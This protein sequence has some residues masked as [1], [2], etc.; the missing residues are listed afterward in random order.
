[1]PFKAVIFDLDG[2]LADT[3]EDIADAM[4]RTLSVNGYPTH[5]YDIYR[6]LVGKGL[7][8]LVTRSLPEQARSETVIEQCYAEML[9]DYTENYINKTRPYSGIQDLLNILSQRAVKMAVLSNKDDTIT[10]KI[11]CKLFPD[12]YFDIVLGSTARFPHKPDPSA[13]LFLAEKM[14]ISPVEVIYLGDSDVDMQTATAAGF[15]AVGAGWGFR[16]E[17]E[18]LN[19]G[20]QKVIHRP[21]EL[22]SLFD[23]RPLYSP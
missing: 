9:D 12:R 4:N 18:L 13:A 10:R 20:A 21:E 1:M 7:K 22:L 2:T 11:C 5:R 23:T 16:P 6:F 17:E 15:Y 8:N 3:L 19:S 14:R